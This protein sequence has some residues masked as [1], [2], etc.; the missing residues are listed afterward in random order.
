MVPERHKE[1]CMNGID[2][3]M[4]YNLQNQVLMGTILGGSSL[5]KPPKG[6]NYYLSMR[7]KDEKWLRYKMAEM[8]SYFQKPKLHLYNNTYRANSSCSPNLTEMQATLYEGNKRIVEMEALNTLM[9]IGIAIWF[10]DGGSKTGRGRKNAYINT[11][12]FGEQGTEVVLQYFNEVGMP[13]HIN[14]DGKRLKILFTV[15]GTIILFKTIA[16][17][18]PSFMYHRL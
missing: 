15:D 5:V 7:N 9:D 4:Q 1:W 3:S 2:R 18:F 12:K 10:L 6:K 16:H 11:T 14:R 8:H 13:C 17:R